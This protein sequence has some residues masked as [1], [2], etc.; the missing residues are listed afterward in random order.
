MDED[1]RLAELLD[2]ALAKGLLPDVDESAPPLVLPPPALLLHTAPV[3]GSSADADGPAMM[4][5]QQMLEHWAAHASD[6]LEQLDARLL[7]GAVARVAMQCGRVCCGKQ[8]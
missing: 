8:H 1:E 4:S 6:C 7:K 3:H 2:S 5:M